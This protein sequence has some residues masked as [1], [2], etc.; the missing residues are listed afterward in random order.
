MSKLKTNRSAAKRFK[1]TKNGKIKRAHSHLR[2]K[3][4]KKSPQRKR[5]LGGTTLVHESDMGRII[6]LLPYGVR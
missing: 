3:L 4:S 6:E 2:H 1:F 5:G